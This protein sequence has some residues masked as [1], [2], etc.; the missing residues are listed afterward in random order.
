[1]ENGCQVC[2]TQV[3]RANITD[4]GLGPVAVGGDYVREAPPLMGWQRIGP[5]LMHV[6]SRMEA[7][8]I[9]AQLAARGVD[10]LEDLSTED[11]A[12]VEQQAVDDAHAAIRAHLADP[13]ASRSWSTMPSYDHL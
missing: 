3:V 5:D 11:R 9:E 10:S 6:G 4:V 2:H 7:A 8:S 13:R 12:A 1:V